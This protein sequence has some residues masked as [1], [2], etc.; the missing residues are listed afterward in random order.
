MHMLRARC[1]EAA[2]GLAVGLQAGGT[3]CSVVDE[4]TETAG[5]YSG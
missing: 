4:M 3:P 2:T 1:G 5:C